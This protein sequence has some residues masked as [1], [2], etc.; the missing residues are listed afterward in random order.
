MTFNKTG[1]LK[2]EQTASHIDNMSE[3]HS[4]DTCFESLPGAKDCSLSP[5]RLG[6]NPRPVYVG[7]VLQKNGI[8]TKIIPPW[9][10]NHN[11]SNSERGEITHVNNKFEECEVM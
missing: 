2:D 7:F 11:L 1:W 9:L 4:G 10:H 6:F 5:W 8:G 3:S